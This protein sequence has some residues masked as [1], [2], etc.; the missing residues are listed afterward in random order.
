MEAGDGTV[1]TARDFPSLRLGKSS[2]AVAIPCRI[3]DQNLPPYWRK[4]SPNCG[5]VA[6]STRA[7][8][9]P[10]SEF[11]SRSKNHQRAGGRVDRYQICP[12]D[13]Y[14]SRQWN[15]CHLSPVTC[16]FLFFVLAFICLVGT[17]IKSCHPPLVTCHFEL[18]MP[19]A[20]WPGRESRG[21]GRCGRNN[22]WRQ[23]R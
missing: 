6:C 11:R 22:R 7:R 19:G 14:L 16:H 4:Q 18:A 8:G 9:N 10:G 17:T 23:R 21:F 1:R 15:F 20:F 12:I 13:L 5:P 3:P 2:N